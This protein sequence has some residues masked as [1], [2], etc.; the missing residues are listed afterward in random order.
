MLDVIRWLKQL[1]NAITQMSDLIYS[2][3]GRHKPGGAD[4]LFPADFNI[5]PKTDNAYNLGSSSYRWRNVYAYN[6][7]VDNIYAGG[8]NVGEKLIRYDDTLLSFTNTTSTTIKTF[9]F[10]RRGWRNMRIVLSVWGDGANTVYVEIA[11]DGNIVDSFSTTAGAETVFERTIDISGIADN[12]LHTVD[13]KMYVDSGT[14]YT[15]F[16]E[17]W[18]W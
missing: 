1:R 8:V 7:Y 3:A 12:T 18:V 6:I 5:E 15:Q 2:H 13:V 16:L 11:V 10:Y 14:G 4:P 9:R 17:A